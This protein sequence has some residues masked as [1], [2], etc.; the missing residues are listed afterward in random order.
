M[1]SVSSGRD[2]Y[3]DY[4]K[5][6][7]ILAVILIHTTAPIV[8]GSVSGAI[9]RQFINFPVFIFFVIAGYFAHYD[10]KNISYAAYVRKKISRL[11][12]TFIFFSVLTGIVR[13]YFLN[14][15]TLESCIKA[16]LS[17]SQGFGYFIIALIQCY[18]LF[19]FILKIKTEIWRC[20]IVLFCYVISTTLFYYLV[21]DNPNRQGVEVPMPSIFF[22]TWIAPFYFGNLLSRSKQLLNTITK[23]RSYCLLFL[24]VSSL[25]AIIEGLHFLVNYRL[26]TTSQ[27]NISTYVQ[28]FALALV[29]FGYHRKIIRPNFIAIIGQTSFF[30][31]LS[32]WFLIIIFRKLFTY[33]PHHPELLNVWLIVIAVIGGEVL[34]V[35]VMNKLNIPWINTLIGVR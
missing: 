11:A 14:I 15:F 35:F 7:A 6:I 16:F 27:I 28:S 12:P 34:M 29:I 25:L 10:S 24:V 18:V 5:A 26:I 13:L 8:I 3:W 1:P 30:V 17:L 21:F 31:Y 33:L 32:H 23:Y 2:F 9:Y 20:T 22:I 19:P 4:V